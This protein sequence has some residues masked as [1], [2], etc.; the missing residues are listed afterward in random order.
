[1]VGDDDANAAPSAWELVGLGGFIVA[2]VVAGLAVGGLADHH[3]G[4][5]PVGILV[6]L[7]VGVVVAIAG[8]ALRVASYLRR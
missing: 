4:S 2:S 3:W 5:T 1:V 8:A 6:G 7:A